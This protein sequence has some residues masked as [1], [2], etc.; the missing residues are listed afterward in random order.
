MAKFQPVSVKLKDGGELLIR[1]AAPEDGEALLEYLDAVSGESDNLT[2]GP[3]E[4]G[5]TLAEEQ[6]YLRKMQER[7]NGIYLLGILDGEIAATL[8]FAAG[9]RPRIAHV[10][11][12]GMSVRQPHWHRGIGTALLS[13]F[14][15]WCHETGIIRKVNLRVRADNQRAMAL[16]EKCGFKVEGRMSR[17]MRVH[18]GFVDT[19][20]MG[21]EID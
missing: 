2:F 12:F 4:F 13:A 1:E 17:D 21:K 10:G 7:K 14:L 6:E 11:E 18:G 3:G 16:Y 20:L 9:G 5:V 15:D 8:S 19:V